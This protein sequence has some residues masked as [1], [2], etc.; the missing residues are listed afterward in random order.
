MWETKRHP[1]PPAEWLCRNTR[2]CFPYNVMLI[3]KLET[4]PDPCR[5]K[6]IA[7]E[8]LAHQNTGAL[9]RKYHSSS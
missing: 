1:V 4:K 5:C 7:L 9:H 8:H 2:L 3:I 6:L